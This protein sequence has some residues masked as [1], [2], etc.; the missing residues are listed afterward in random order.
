MI[1]HEKQNQLLDSIYAGLSPGIYM[2]NSFLFPSVDKSFFG[3]MLRS[4][5]LVFF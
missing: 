4:T 1:N 5:K 2:V 3:I